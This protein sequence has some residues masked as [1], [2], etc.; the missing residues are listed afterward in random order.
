MAENARDPGGTSD[1]SALVETITEMIICE[2]QRRGITITR[3]DGS[4][5][6][7]ADRCRVILN[8]A[9]RVGADR[10]GPEPGLGPVPDGLEKYIDH[11]LLK[12]EATPEDIDRFGELQWAYAGR[13]A[14]RPASETTQIQFLN[15]FQWPDP[16]CQD[17]G[18]RRDNDFKAQP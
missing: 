12:P 17:L 3:D 1:R 8:Q 7:S 18:R 4:P 10:V 14:A 2:L 5:A 13:L 6:V 9:I 11:T 16:T 15:G